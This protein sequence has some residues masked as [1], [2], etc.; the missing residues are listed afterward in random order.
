MSTGVG[1]R[2]IKELQQCRTNYRHVYVIY[3]VLNVFFLILIVVFFYLLFY[4]FMKLHLLYLR[5][6]NKGISE[7]QRQLNNKKLHN[8]GSELCVKKCTKFHLVNKKI[9]YLQRNKKQDTAAFA[10]LEDSR[11]FFYL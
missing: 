5:L 1:S 7:I 9:C 8:E 6:N 10:A 3:C 11:I 2:V 4:S